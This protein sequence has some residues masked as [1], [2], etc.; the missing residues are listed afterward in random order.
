MVV[1]MPVIMFV[2]IIVL[3]RVIVVVPMRMVMPVAMCMGVPVMVVMPM[4]VVMVTR[5]GLVMHPGRIGSLRHTWIFAEHKR[6][7]RNRN[8]QGR[9]SDA[10]QIDVT[11]SITINSLLISS[12]S[13][14][15]APK[16]C[17]RSP[18]RIK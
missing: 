18:S 4:P 3:M 2:G 7:H 1:A 15:N 6:L 13:R 9:D 14:M 16:D 10:P 12:S 8:G 5:H 17:A 11:P